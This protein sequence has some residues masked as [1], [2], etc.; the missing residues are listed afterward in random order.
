MD[1]LFANVYG[2]LIK[3]E[4]NPEGINVDA[5][6]AVTKGWTNRNPGSPHPFDQN[7]L[8]PNC[9]DIDSL[10]MDWDT[11]TKIVDD[12]RYDKYTIE[13]ILKNITFF[14]KNKK[15]KTFL[16]NYIQDLDIIDVH[17]IFMSLIGSMLEMGPSAFISEKD[18]EY[19]KVYNYMEMTLQADMDMSL[20]DQTT[21]NLQNEF[22]KLGV[23]GYLTEAVDFPQN[24]PHAEEMIDNLIAKGIQSPSLRI[25]FQDWSEDF[26]K[27]YNSHELNC[28]IFMDGALAAIYNNPSLFFTNG[29]DSTEY[30]IVKEYIMEVGYL[31]QRLKLEQITTKEVMRRA[32]RANVS[33]YVQSIEEQNWN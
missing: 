6:A 30:Q 19:T 33:Q 4:W 31:T 17:G 11:Y 8:V 5:I 2:K 18:Y 22:G 20:T 26:G 12:I 7:W 13:D 14:L 23:L 27:L 21:I 9:V 16:Q 25:T 10:G 3:Q 32:E 15:R 28:A 29:Q 24:I 1:K